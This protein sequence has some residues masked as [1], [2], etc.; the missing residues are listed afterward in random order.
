MLGSNSPTMAPKMKY[1]CN[2][3]SPSRI[4]LAKRLERQYYLSWKLIFIFILYKKVGAVS[5]FTPRDNSRID[6]G[7]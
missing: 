2:F 3:V 4:L 1:S 5:H 7:V 6:T